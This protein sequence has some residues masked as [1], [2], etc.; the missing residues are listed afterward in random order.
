MTAVGLQVGR[1]T[2]DDAAPAVRVWML[3]VLVIGST[4]GF[5][6]LA[7][8]LAI[9]YGIAPS[10]ALLSETVPSALVLFTLYWMQRGAP[11]LSVSSVTSSRAA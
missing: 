5:M 3:A 2:R 8:S 6:N 7:V 10:L 4:V 11:T 9:E 1:V